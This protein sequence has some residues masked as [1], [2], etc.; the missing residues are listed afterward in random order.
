M[1]KHVLE[2]FER[3]HQPRRQKKHK[4]RSGELT[5]LGIEAGFHEGRT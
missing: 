4:V 3:S 2:V 1:R 5:Y